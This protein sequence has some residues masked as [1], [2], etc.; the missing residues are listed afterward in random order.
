MDELVYQRKQQESAEEY[1]SRCRRC[2]ACCGAYDGDP[3][4]NLEKAADNRYFCK[5]YNTRLGLQKTISG[6]SFTCVLIRENL[7]IS[8]LSFSCCPYNVS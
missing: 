4:I 1:E 5:V 2:G 8:P 6:K 3:C 7:K